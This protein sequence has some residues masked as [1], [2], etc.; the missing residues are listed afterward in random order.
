MHSSR[1]PVLKYRSDIDGLRAIAVLFVVA[2]HAFPEVVGGG[3]IGVDVFFVISGFLISGIIFT[4]LDRERFSFLDFYSRRI[5][6]IFPALLVVLVAC[7]VCGWFVLGGSEY[8]QLGKHMAAGAAFVSNF[9]LWGEA[10]YFDSSAE[11]KLLIHLWSLGVEEQFYLVWPLLLWWAQRIKL[12]LIAPALGIAVISFAA[13][14]EFIEHNPVATFY[15]PF[16]RFWELLSGAVLAWVLAWSATASGRDAALAAGERIGLR[17]WCE[18]YKHAIA[19]AIACSGV[20]LLGYA[21]YK[22][23]AAFL[24]PGAWAAIPVAATVLIIAAGPE[25]WLNRV[26]LSN[27]AMVGLGLISYP[28]YLWHWPLLTFAHI[29]KNGALTTNVRILIVVIAVLLSWL[30]YQWVERPIRF[31]P[32]SKI[33][34]IV[35]LGLMIVV[36]GVGYLTYAENGFEFRLPAEVRGGKGDAVSQWLIDVRQ[37]RCHL[38]ELSLA[39][40]DAVCLE[41]KR[42]LIALWGDSHAAA[43]YPGLR[44]LQEQHEFGV[45]QFTQAACPPIFSLEGSLVRKNCNAINEKI[46]QRLVAASPEVVLL[47]AAWQHRYYPMSSA[48]LE[49]KLTA[50]LEKLKEQLPHSRIIVLGPVPRW[51]KGPRE[52]SYRYWQESV[53]KTKK[54]P[55]YL[56]AT[57]DGELEEIVSVAAM[58]SGA[59]YISM[60]AL[61]CGGA[62]C[63]AR[64][65][66]RAEDFIAIDSAHFSRSGSAYVV[67]KLWPR[68][69]PGEAVHR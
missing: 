37:D 29:V 55:F 38:Q 10:G 54:I 49:T 62:S 17:G 59:E 60:S 18:R 58:K 22:I 56:P 19:N 69:S 48:E 41:S 9:A 50:S 66:D 25:A 31:G 28:L 35:L 63:L 12:P 21:L 65:G 23:K 30:T 64:I 36:G 13:N 1:S 16:S 47:H 43:L 53:D 57:V 44:K 34:S 5:R 14:L 7:Y 68:L 27:R 8:K 42:P 51:D 52:A 4:D 3:F 67:E 6:R 40:H 33:R 39:E 15:L 46:L 20:L 32:A 45:A 26:L 2:F 24:F 11:T 61:L